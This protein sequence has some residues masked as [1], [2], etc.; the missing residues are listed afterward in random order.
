MKPVKIAS[1]YQRKIKLN[2]SIIITCPEIIV[3][4][5]FQGEEI[6]GSEILKYRLLLIHALLSVV[7]IKK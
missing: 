3:K 2:A 5:K 1:I 7:Y 6:F 4:Q